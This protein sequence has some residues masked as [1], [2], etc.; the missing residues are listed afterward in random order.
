MLEM[1]QVPKWCLGVAR[2]LLQDNRPEHLIRQEKEFI[3]AVNKIQTLTTTERGGMSIDL[4]E[5]RD[6]IIEA[7]DSYKHLVNAEHRRSTH[8]QNTQEN[9]GPQPVNAPNRPIKSINSHSDYIELV[10]WRHHSGGAAIRYLCL[11]SLGT[12]KF[13]VAAT[14]YFPN[15]HNTTEFSSPTR[16]IAERLKSSAHGE[17]LDWFPS[18]SEA[19]DALDA[20]F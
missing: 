12:L 8:H 11:Q 7:R 4:E 16:E 6:Q 10:T 3:E 5:I 19:M 18:L 9:Q 1:R 13:A 20:S 15:T 17:P 2:H 14:Q